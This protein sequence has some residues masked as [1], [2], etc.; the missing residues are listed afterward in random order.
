MSP[1]LVVV[2][3]WRIDVLV[4]CCTGV[5]MMP[6]K[7]VDNGMPEQ[8]VYNEAKTVLI[9][10]IVFLYESHGSSYGQRHSKQLG[11][12]GSRRKLKFL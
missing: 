2:L 5:I 3:Y 1:G 6:R 10:M 7:M 8:R 12:T 4:I 9:F 11:F